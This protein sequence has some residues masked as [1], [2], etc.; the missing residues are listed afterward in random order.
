MKISTETLAILKNFSTINSNITFKPGN[1]LRTVSNGNS[2]FSQATVAETFDREFGIYDIGR[3]LATMSLFKDPDLQFEKECIV[4]K[5]GKS[6]VKFYYTDPSLLSKVPNGVKMPS[7]AV[8]FDFSSKDLADLLKAGNVL[9]APDICI[10]C[11]S[12]NKSLQIIALD[13]KDPTSN[14][15][16]LDLS[17]IVRFSD[18]DGDVEAELFIKAEYL[19]MIPG[20]YVINISKKNIVQFVGDKNDM[21]YYVSLESSS[22]W[23]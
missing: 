17:D 6:E 5:S 4:I 7:I 22:T 2:I 10:K 19:K 13:K 1:T 11:S 8:S 3:F 15:Y 12:K 21:M 20:D 9:Q 14:K 18:Q 16:T 23:N